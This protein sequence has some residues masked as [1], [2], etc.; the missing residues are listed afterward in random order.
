MRKR[1][2][3]PNQER[4][5]GAPSFLIGRHFGYF[6]LAARRSDPGGYVVASE[7]REGKA[8]HQVG[9]RRNSTAKQRGFSEARARTFHPSTD[10]DPAQGWRRGSGVE[11]RGEGSG[12]CLRLSIHCSCADGA[13]ELFGAL[14]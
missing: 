14:S 8:A 1:K 11:I 4:A 10:D 9:R 12:S 2:P 7:V 5:R 13:A 6:E 3:R